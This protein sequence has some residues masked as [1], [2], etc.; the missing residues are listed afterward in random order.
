[1]RWL[2]LIPLLVAF[3]PIHD[4]YDTKEKIKD[5]FRNIEQNLQPVQFKV[6]ATT[7]ALADLQ[8]G[9]IVIIS[10]GINQSLIWRSQAEIYA[11]HGS[12]ITIVR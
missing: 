7:P 12:C 11:V 1:M 8:D 10:S 6:F 3:T 5:E 9:E 2:W 4:I